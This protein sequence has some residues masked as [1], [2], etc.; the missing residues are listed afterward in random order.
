MSILAEE[1]ALPFLAHMKESSGRAIIVV[2]QDIAVTILVRRIYAC[3]CVSVEIC[4]GHNSYI[5]AWISK[6]FDPVGVLEEEKCH[7]KHFLG[8]LKVKV[9]LECHIN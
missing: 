9:T 3:V 8:R 4:P 1:A 7:L 6:L 5:Y 2:K